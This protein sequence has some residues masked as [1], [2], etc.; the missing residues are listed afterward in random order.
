MQCIWAM[1]V[2]I[3][4]KCKASPFLAL[5]SCFSHFKQWKGGEKD[6]V[7][8]E[9]NL[10]V[11][12]EVPYLGYIWYMDNCAL[13]PASSMNAGNLKLMSHEVRT[14]GICICPYCKLVNGGCG[15]SHE[16]VE[17]GC[18]STCVKCGGWKPNRTGDMY[19][20]HVEAKSD[21]HRGIVYPV[22]G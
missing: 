1:N 3:Y 9:V 10:V 20:I 13:D 7:R 4:V 21:L 5:S 2:T 17:D 22:M 16:H 8:M 11:W 15:L 19:V 18:K 12:P 6:L 14:P